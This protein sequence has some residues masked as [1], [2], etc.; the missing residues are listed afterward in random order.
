MTEV[1]DGML[2]SHRIGRFVDIES[3]C[4]QPEM[5]PEHG[6]SQAAELRDIG[7]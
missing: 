4:A 7:T 5:L 6:M 3:T 2:E 1:I